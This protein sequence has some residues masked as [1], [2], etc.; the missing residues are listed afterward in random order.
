MDLSTIQ[1]YSKPATFNAVPDWQPGWAWLAGGTWLFSEPQPH[2]TALVDIEP[3]GW[4]EI[5]VE[6]DALVLGASCTLNQL[7]HHPWPAEW[8]ATSLFKSAI[9][10]LAASFKVTQVATLGGNL[11]LALAVGVMAP[12][13]VLLNATYE[14]WQP[15]GEP[16]FVPAQE[17]QEG[18]QQTVL[19]SGEILRRIHI[20]LEFLSWQAA[21]QRFGIAATDPAL[22]L[23]AALYAPN[24]GAIRLSLGACIPAPKL[25]TFSQIPTLGEQQ[26]ALQSMLWL[27]D[28]R[29]SA[30]YRQQVT[31]V[32]LERLLESFR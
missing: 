18:V 6:Q 1:S 8:P 27:N 23:V 9:A 19:R 28:L 25:L 31:A 11:C 16:Y 17:F 12:V 15:D 24:S 22:S 5:R 4:S 21:F 26:T 20:P 7:L 30:I 14:I 29:A 10:A 2:L 3:F 13:M 32:L